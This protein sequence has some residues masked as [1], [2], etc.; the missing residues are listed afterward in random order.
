[1][2]GLNND[3]EVANDRKR[4]RGVVTVLMVSNILYYARKK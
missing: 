1:M 2:S 3:K 4:L